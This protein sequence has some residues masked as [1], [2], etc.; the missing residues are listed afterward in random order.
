MYRNLIDLT[1]VPQNMLFD[2]HIYRLY[3]MEGKLVYLDR[4]MSVF[5]NTGNGFWSGRSYW[6][7]KLMTL[8]LSYEANRYFDYILDKE[9]FEGSKPLGLLKRI[10]GAR[11]GWVAYFH[12]Q[13]IRILFMRRLSTVKGGG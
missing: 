5:N 3:L 12:I 11:K 8:E 7:K 1:D 10:L 2:T 13:K 4:V 9:Y 6:D